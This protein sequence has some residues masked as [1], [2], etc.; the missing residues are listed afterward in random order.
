MIRAHRGV[1]LGSVVSHRCLIALPLQAVL[2]VPGKVWFF[3]DNW[4]PRGAAA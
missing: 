2:D 4:D 1:G 3:F